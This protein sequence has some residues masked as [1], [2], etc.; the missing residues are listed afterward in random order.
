[1]AFTL[2]VIKNVWKDSY[3]PWC[4]HIPVDCLMVAYGEVFKLSWIT[5]NLK[6]TSAQKKLFPIWHL[7]VQDDFST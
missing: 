2:Q 1:M 6:W 5:E 3:G 7:C 4:L